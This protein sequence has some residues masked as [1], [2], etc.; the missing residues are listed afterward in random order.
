V[1][2]E[3]PPGGQGPAPDPGAPDLS[4][5]EL[6][7]ALPGRV[8]LR[9]PG[10]KGEPGLAREIQKQLAGL[11]V[12]RKVEVSAITGSVLVI[13]D[14]ADSAAMAELGRMMIPGLDLGTPPAADG[15]G[16]AA[17]PAE[18]IS[19]YFQQLNAQV[20]SATGNTDLKVLL[21]ATLFLSGILRLVVAKRLTGP[22]WYDLLWFS[23]GT[24]CTLN[25]SSASG[26]A[27][28]AREPASPTA[29][30]NGVAS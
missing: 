16:A 11:K 6:R 9:V 17:P 15:D 26:S 19:G 28:P 27:A 5:I 20:R 18:Q 14:P 21:P 30:A 10:I 3:R 8:R 7:H 13:Y 25:G 23:F 2:D 22:T 24:F 12:V 29:H 4:G 1:E